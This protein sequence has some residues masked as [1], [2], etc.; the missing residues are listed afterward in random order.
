MNGIFLLN[1]IRVKRTDFLGTTCCT[2]IGLY[3]FTLMSNTKTFPSVVSAARTVL[4]YGAH[5]TSPTLAPRSNMNNGSL[6]KSKIVNLNYYICLNF[7][8]LRISSHILTR[9]SAAHETNIFELNL[10]KSIR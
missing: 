9:Q 7:H 4:E 5:L 8:Y 6:K 3:L 1:A 2:Q 10:L